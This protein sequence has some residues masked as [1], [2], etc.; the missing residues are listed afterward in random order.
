LVA[1]EMGAP[2]YKKLGFQILHETTTF[3]SPFTF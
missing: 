3:V 2:V 1:S